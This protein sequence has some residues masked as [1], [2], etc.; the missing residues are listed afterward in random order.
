M[1]DDTKHLVAD[2][3]RKTF[4]A[5]RKLRKIMPQFTRAQKDW[6]AAEERRLHD[7]WWAEVREYFVKGPNDPPFTPDKCFRVWRP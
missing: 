1:D 2:K 3:A 4:Q 7:Q 5:I 6:L